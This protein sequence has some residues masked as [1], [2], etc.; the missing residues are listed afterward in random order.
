MSAR[1]S[2]LVGALAGC[3]LGTGLLVGQALARHGSLDPRCLFVVRG[4]VEQ[5]LIDERGV[6][7]VRCTYEYWAGGAP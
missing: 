3:L 6:R 7:S 1:I 4:Y 5:H 2:I